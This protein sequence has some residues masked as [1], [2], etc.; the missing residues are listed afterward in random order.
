MLVLIVTQQIYQA[1]RV[2]LLQV[3]ELGGVGAN[4]QDHPDFVMKYRCRQPV[5][6]YPQTKPLAQVAS[7]THCLLLPGCL[8]DLVTCVCAVHYCAVCCAVQCAVPCSVLCAVQCATCDCDSRRWLMS[9]WW[10][11][12]GW[13]RVAAGPDRRL[14]F[15]PLRCRG[16]RPLCAGHPVRLSIDPANPPTADDYDCSI[17]R[18]VGRFWVEVSVPHGLVIS[19]DCIAFQRAHQQEGGLLL[20]VCRYPDLQF[21]ISPIAMEGN[22]FKPMQEHA[23]QM[24]VGL[25]RAHSRG[26]I[27]LRSADPAAP[28]HILCNYLE[29]GRDR[30]A[31]RCT[32]GGLYDPSS[33][34]KPAPPIATC[35]GA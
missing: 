15:Q 22:S 32:L 8:Q 18:L 31:I 5:T 3:A 20:F 26:R 21:T 1:S 7:I 33:A 9:S 14:R 6:L 27:K 4:L 24:H 35:N 2:V 19:S 23:F 29:D 13:A 30:A 34:R 16:Q 10:A 28:P 11:G 25:M 12:R 17:F